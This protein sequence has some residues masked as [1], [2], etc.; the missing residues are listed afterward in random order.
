MKIRKALSIAGRFIDG[1]HSAGMKTTGKHFPGHG[2]V[3]A[4]SHKETPR[5]PRAQAEI[6]AKIWRCSA[7]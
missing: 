1:M 5:D 2:A 3:T 4:D 6:R 7:R